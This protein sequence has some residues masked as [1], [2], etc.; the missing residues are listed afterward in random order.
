LP[1]QTACVAHDFNS[2]PARFALRYG[3]PQEAR[4]SDMPVLTIRH[5]TEYCYAKPVSFGEHRVMLRPRDG[6]DLRVIDLRMTI[7]PEPIS[8]RWIHDVFG[9]SVG[10][11]KFEGQSD[12]LVFQSE[13]TIDHDPTHGIDLPH[14]DEA[15]HYPFEY[16]P[17]VMPDLWRSISRQ[18]PDRDGTIE[19][20]ARQFVNA[21]GP[22]KTRDLLIDIT[23][24]IKLQFTY[25]RRLNPG[26]QSPL[27]TLQLRRG[28]CRDFAL[29]MIEAV[30]SLGFAARFVSGYL[31][32]PAKSG[33]TGGGSTHAWVQ[34]YLPSAGW[35]EF[36][37]TNGIVGNHDLIRVAVAREPRQ[38][39][40]LWGTFKGFLSDSIGMKVD[41]DVVALA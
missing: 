17:E 16:E 5:K 40:P 26:V 15:F 28:T 23:H 37:P 2:G 10:I 24:A 22:T 12:R 6:H 7:D 1:H 20:W 39:V 29:F 32:V 34:V 14:D 33:N 31:H 21:S 27:E 13:A 8:L 3:D 19:A 18:Y 38:A 41:I 9:N 25:R 30:R 35:V 11:A 36:D 4:K